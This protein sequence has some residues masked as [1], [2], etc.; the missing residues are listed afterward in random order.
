VEIPQFL[1]RRYHWLFGSPV[2]VHT[3]KCGGTYLAHALGSNLRRIDWRG[4]VNP[5]DI[6][7]RRDLYALI[8]HP[9]SWYASYVTFCRKNLHDAPQTR[10]NF[11]LS[12][13]ITVLSD[14]G[15]L[16]V[17]ETI[18]RLCDDRVIAE[19][20]SSGET[21]VVYGRDIPDLWP[22][23]LRTG[24]GF[25]TWTLVDLLHSG[26]TTEIRDR[27]SLLAVLEAIS[28]RVTFLRLE[29]LESDVA[30][31]LRL[32]LESQQETQ[33][34]SSK[35]FRGRKDDPC[36]SITA[37]LWDREGQILGLLGHYEDPNGAI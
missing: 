27:A 3:P 14:S 29:H 8:R 10:E 4:H 1:I 33:R 35:D 21:P 32:D 24:S 5:R 22:F 2:I 28:R 7:G 37:K 26:P 12:H 17:P 9:Y 20:E 6:R 36:D 18:N 30:R 11:P 16:S 13:P 31:F 25:Y 23:I 34:N 19:L 15:R